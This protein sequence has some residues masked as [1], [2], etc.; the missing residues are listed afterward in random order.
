MKELEEAKKKREADP[1]YSFG[2]VYKGFNANG[3]NYDDIQSTLGNPY[4]Y[5]NYRDSLPDYFYNPYSMPQS[6]D[7]EPFAE[8]GG[9]LFWYWFTR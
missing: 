4:S 6:N 7:E 8:D 1:Q 9:R 5:T 3:Y 2:P